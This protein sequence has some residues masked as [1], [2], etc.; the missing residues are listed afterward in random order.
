MASLA[1]FYDKID[2]PECGGA[3]LSRKDFPDID[4]H[5]ELQSSSGL[6]TP[7]ATKRF[8]LLMRNPLLTR[9]FVAAKRQSSFL[10][11]FRCKVVFE[12]KS[13]QNLL[14]AENECRWR[15]WRLL[16]DI[17]WSVNIRLSIKLH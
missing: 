6:S 10:V 8:H 5:L 15:W 12:S 1:Y 13:Q 4:L 2:G 17:R 11:L 3:K 14:P 16:N 9:I 7:S